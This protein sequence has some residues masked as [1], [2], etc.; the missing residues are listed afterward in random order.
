MVASVKQL[1]QEALKQKLKPKQ[2]KNWLSD[3]LGVNLFQLEQTLRTGKT[4]WPLWQDL[5]NHPV[6]QLV[7]SLSSAD[8]STLSAFIQLSENH[9]LNLLIQVFLVN[10]EQ[11]LSKIDRKLLFQFLH[12]DNLKHEISHLMQSIEEQMK[13][14][15]SFKCLLAIHENSTNDIKSLAELSGLLN[16][17]PF[18]PQND[19]I[20]LIHEL[21]FHHL[22]TDL[23]CAES[24]AF[25]DFFILLTHKMNAKQQKKLIK[26]LT[27]EQVS[28]LLHYA[29][30]A[31]DSSHP[32]HRSHALSVLIFLLT[33]SQYID[34]HCQKLIQ[35]KL[36]PFAHETQNALL[37]QFNFYSDELPYLRNDL[38]VNAL[39]RWF[40]P[41][42]ENKDEK[43]PKAVLLTDAKGNSLGVLNATN[44]AL[45]WVNKMPVLLVQ[46]S[47]A[48]A[49]DPVYVDSK[50]YGYLTPSGHVRCANEVSKNLSADFLASIPIGQL[51]DSGKLSLLVEHVLFEQ[52]VKTLFELTKDES[53]R[54][55]LERVICTQLITSTKTFE[56]ELFNHL[57]QI[58]QVDSLFHVLSLIQHK[59]NAFHLMHSMLSDDRLRPMILNGSHS[60]D[61]NNF[62][63]QHDIS[64]CLA[65]YLANCH[66]KP[67]FQQGLTQFV[68][69]A[70]KFQ[71]NHA[72]SDALALLSANA[73]TTESQKSMDHLLSML[74][75]DEEL[76]RL[77]LRE[78]CGI[79]N[80][81]PVQELNELESA[82]E[83][84]RLMAFFSKKHIL[85][86]IKSLNNTSFWES[87]AQYQ[88]VLHLLFHRHQQLF[89]TPPQG[90]WNA[91]ELKELSL[92]TAR[93]FTKK[94]PLD[95]GYA[96]GNRLLGEL[97]FRGAQLGQASFFYDGVTFHKVIPRLTISHSLLM[98]LVDKFY[99]TP[100]IKEDCDQQ[101]KP[102]FDSESAPEE[103]AH[104]RYLIDW[105]SLLNEFWK[106]DK[107]KRVPILFV[108]L[109]NFSGDK[110]V[111]MR[112]L[113]DYFNSL[114][115]TID[116]ISPISQLLD[117][118]PNR[119]VSALVFEA[120]EAAVLQHPSLFTTPIIN[121]MA[122]YYARNVLHQ[123]SGSPEAELDLLIYF[124]QHKKYQVVRQGC[125]E[126]AKTCDNLGIR[127][128]LQ[129]G[130]IEAQTEESLNT[131]KGY[132]YFS[133]VK[134]L[135]RLWNYG[136]NQRLSQIV[137]L[138]DDESIAPQKPRTVNKVQSLQSTNKTP[139]AFQ[140]KKQQLINLLATINQSSTVKSNLSSLPTKHTLLFNKECSS[141][142]IEHSAPAL[143]A[144]Y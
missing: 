39:N 34:E 40:T 71:K 137:K 50:L 114:H 38:M 79:T 63:Q 116:Y 41:N 136:F 45:T 56:P 105:V 31:M 109:V 54:L 2:L 27:T 101:N 99:V 16:E 142:P 102:L 77:M 65:E 129:Q 47:A 13:S 126:V 127:K 73:D 92:F 112:L 18:T 21:Y 84:Q 135:K 64:Y 17:Y 90:E 91:E 87:K 98:S 74:V 128:K 6:N 15:F 32:S 7:R 49:K 72:L 11:D 89:A 88:L 133:L 124:G 117:F 93:H 25:I 46:T 130:Y 24:H 107:Q 37:T 22:N 123:Y 44:E 4:A 70:K 26:N 80:A 60:S 62:F 141:Y 104:H 5:N 9:T 118:L 83:L 85:G 100:G 69:Y 143:E 59:T 1:A 53:K 42:K 23:N 132:F 121:H 68:L 43:V 75:A 28:L 97:L 138:C 52:T 113:H 106:G 86:A 14:A 66:H 125:E 115:K 134:T 103:L 57:T 51:V 36:S 108:Y 131:S 140:D 20:Q 58:L 12:R 94:R 19:S 30:N 110:K 119:E 96:L 78:F 61:V 111:L 76:S 3:Q 139:I 35:H 82:Q 48:R 10:N 67:W 81:Q 33:H 95:K 120:L 122:S 144:V 8:Q 29:L 55:W